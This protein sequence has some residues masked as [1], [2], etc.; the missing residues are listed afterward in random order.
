MPGADLR[1]LAIS[2]VVAFAVVVCVPRDVGAQTTTAR[3]S[4]A[5][6]SNAQGIDI[7]DHQHSEGPIRWE[8]V[9]RHYQFAFIKATEGT[10]YVNRYYASDSKAAAAAGLNVGGYAFATPDDASGASEAKYFLQQSRYARHRTLL[11][12]MLDLEWN[13]Y[14][15]STS[16]Y[17]LT[18]SDLVAWVGSYSATIDRTLGVKPIIYTQASFWNHCV[19]GTS[20][21]SDSPLWVGSDGTSSTTIPG[22]FSTWAIWQYGVGSASGV[23]G[24]VDVDA[25]NGT[26]SQLE[27]ELSAKGLP[28]DQPLQPY[29]A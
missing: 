29:G 2:A 5:E 10:S 7:S 1:G 24:P 16:C 17:G 9:G 14:H 11:F 8:V 12:P 21:F 26:T 6:V 15:T 13:P 20:A 19:G 28:R 27:T 25:F 22:G 18:P 23:D 3:P 4:V